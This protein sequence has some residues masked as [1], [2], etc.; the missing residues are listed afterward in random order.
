MSKTIPDD[1]VD[2]PQH[3]V[4]EDGI[5]LPKGAGLSSA[6][7]QDDFDYRTL[8][9][10]EIRKLAHA[11]AER[12][13]KS[14]QSLR[15]DD[16]IVY[17]Q[18]HEISAAPAQSARPEHGINHPSEQP[19]GISRE[20]ALARVNSEAYQRAGLQEPPKPKAKT[21][22]QIKADAK[23]AEIL[24]RI[25]EESNS[26]VDID[27]F[28]DAMEGDQYSIPPE[29]VPEGFSVEFKNTSVM[30]QPVDP[31]YNATLEQGGWVPCPAEIFPTLV[32][33]GYDKP[34]IERPGMILMIRP[35]RITDAVNERR[36]E[37]ARDQMTEKVSQM[38]D[39]P[40]DSMDRV[41]TTFDKSYETA[42]TRK[43]VPQ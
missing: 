28:L 29:L 32:P 14:L 41:V 37:R 18:A 30:G 21:E 25:E 33:R 16:L 42:P 7:A 12:E 22:D 19:G 4:G 23:R 15:Q 38:Y 31:S 36:I 3:T 8:S 11:K 17:L 20:E 9:Y 5:A 34:Y 43:A 1:T 10:Q 13:G 35:K 27:K 39:T 24:A 6:P 26:R 2:L 40:K